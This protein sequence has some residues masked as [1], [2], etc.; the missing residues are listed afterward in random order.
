MAGSVPAGRGCEGVSWASGN[1]L[2]LHRG[3]GSGG[4]IAMSNDLLGRMLK[5]Y[6]LYCMSAVF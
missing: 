3:G 1:V 6:A 2:C 4:A 5:I